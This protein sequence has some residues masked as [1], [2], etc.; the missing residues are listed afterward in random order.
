MQFTFEYTQTV[1]TG[2]SPQAIHSKDNLLRIIYLASDN[3]VHGLY[4]D[5]VLGLYDSLAFEEQGRISPDDNVSFPSIKRVAHYGAF[6]F[7]SAEGDHRF[8]VYNMPTDISRA[9]VDGSVQY[10]MNS[11]VSSL[12]CSLTNI[13]GELLN[14]YRALVTPGTKLEVYFS[15]GSSDEVPLGVYYIDRADVSY[16]D[17]AVS[18][19]A[20]NAIGKLLKEQTFDENTTLTEGSLHDNLEAIMELAGVEHYFIGDS[21]TNPELVFEPD[22]TL[23]EGIRYAI[24][25][26]RG[27]KIGET[28]AGFVG[29]A[30]ENDARYEPIGVYAFERD[31]T[32]WSYSIEY[33]D[34]DAASRVCVYSK[35][36]EETDEDVRVY[37]NVSFNKWWEHPRHRTL[38]VTTIDGATQEQCLAI[39]NELSA[40]LAASGR[41][42]TFAGLFTPQLAL[43]DE[44]QITGD[45]AKVDILGSITDVTHNFG[46][47][48]FYTSFTVDSG[49]RKG[50]TRLKELIDTASSNPDAFTGIRPT[51]QNGDEMSF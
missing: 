16:P 8:V 6:G 47:G 27:W 17:G 18:V 24:S 33:D 12:S 48:G 14:R 13:R 21:G 39:A 45:D 44:V 20:R 49:G 9:L 31:R 37:V 22:T 50:R 23:L 36:K 30:P 1:G 11:E 38:H 42:E 25:L 10:S 46:K 28:S 51:V 2:R 32:C 15:I 34:S 29:I 19:S 40:S 5:P 7:W 3:T 4:V 26:L 43:G 35:G 41:K